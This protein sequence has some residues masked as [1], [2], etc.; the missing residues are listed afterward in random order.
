MIKERQRNT[1]LTPVMGQPGDSLV[2]EVTDHETRK[3]QSF[4]ESIGRKITIDTIVTFDVIGPTLGLSE[5]IGAI[6]GKAT[7][8]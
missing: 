8:E 1:L 5:G 2:C 3:M 7:P 4:K 6:F